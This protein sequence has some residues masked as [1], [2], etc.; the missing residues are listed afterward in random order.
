[1]AAIEYTIGFLL[2]GILAILPRKYLTKKYDDPN[3]RINKK[4]YRILA[5]IV[6]IGFLIMAIVE[7]F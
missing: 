5:G 1:M 3:N 7:F 4:S 2:F 6:S